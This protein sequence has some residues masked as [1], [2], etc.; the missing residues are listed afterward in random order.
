M[1]IV[2][3]GFTITVVKTIVFVIIIINVKNL[4]V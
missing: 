4:A 1:S 2:L 3:L